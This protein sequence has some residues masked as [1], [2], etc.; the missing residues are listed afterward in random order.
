M[1]K[2][3]QTKPLESKNELLMYLLLTISGNVIY[4]APCMHQKDRPANKQ[5]SPKDAMQAPSYVFDKE[6]SYHDTTCNNLLA[7]A[8]RKFVCLCLLEQSSTTALH[9]QKPVL[10]HFQKYSFFIHQLPMKQKTY[11]AQLHDS[12][13]EP[14][15]KTCTNNKSKHVFFKLLQGQMNYSQIV[16]KI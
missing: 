3:P 14:Q 12:E 9:T 4:Q 15:A 11:H 10:S 5:L 7:K 16:C 13:H 6:Q 1:L 2:Q 8:L